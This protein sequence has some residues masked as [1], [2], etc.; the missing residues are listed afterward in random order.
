ML[1]L[2]N[3]NF[4]IRW[5]YEN[6]GDLGVVVQSSLHQNWSVTAASPFDYNIH[7]TLPSYL[8]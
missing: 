3:C 4:F 1:S 5:C 6:D 7:G 2:H 8:V